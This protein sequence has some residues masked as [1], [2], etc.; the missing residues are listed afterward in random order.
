MEH[1]LRCSLG[2]NMFL[3]AVD[4]YVKLFYP[5]FPKVLEE[6]TFMDVRRRTAR[7]V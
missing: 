4:K 1:L 5:D 3:C 7:R 6:S 2:F